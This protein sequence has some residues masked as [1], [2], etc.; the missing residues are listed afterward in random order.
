MFQNK[1]FSKAFDLFN[2]IKFAKTL[3]CWHNTSKY[4]RNPA[5]RI[6]KI[7][8]SPFRYSKIETF[9]N[10]SC[11]EYNRKNYSQHFFKHTN[12]IIYFY[13]KIRNVEDRLFVNENLYHFHNNTQFCIFA[14]ITN[15]SFCH[16]FVTNTAYV[17]FQG[18]ENNQEYK[19]KHNFIIIEF[20]NFCE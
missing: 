13:Y 15:S 7:R 8:F 6:I 16:V 3:Y 19:P 20:N 12:I 17:T 9:W 18:I 1:L 5:I 2:I 4:L 14:H 10:L 11:E